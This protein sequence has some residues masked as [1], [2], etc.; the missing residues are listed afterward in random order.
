[1]SLSSC[2]E[3]GETET[4]RLRLV[5][6]QWLTILRCLHILLEQMVNWKDS[7]EQGIGQI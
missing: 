1:M 5:T 4:K 7:G 3:E 2:N 6:T